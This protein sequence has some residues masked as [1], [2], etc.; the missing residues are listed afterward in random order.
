M[1]SSHPLDSSETSLQ[2]LVLLLDDICILPAL[3]GLALLIH[4]VRPLDADLRVQVG[5]RGPR[6]LVGDGRGGWIVIGGARKADEVGLAVH[7]VLLV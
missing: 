3:I 1:S 6:G 5:V 2:I 7:V 4:L